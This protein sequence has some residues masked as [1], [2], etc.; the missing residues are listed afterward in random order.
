[1]QYL[2]CSQIC[3]ALPLG[4]RQNPQPCTCC[5]LSLERRWGHSSMQRSVTALSCQSHWLQWAADDP[6]A[7]GRYDQYEERGPEL[8]QT[9]PT[10]RPALPHRIPAATASLLVGCLTAFSTHHILH[11]YHTTE[12]TRHQL[13]STSWHVWR[14]L[15]HWVPVVIRWVKGGNVTSAGWQVTLCDAI[16][17]ASSSS[18]EAH[19]QLLNWLFY[20]LY[21]TILLLDVSL[22]KISNAIAW[23]WFCVST[24]APII[25]QSKKINSL[26]SNLLHLHNFSTYT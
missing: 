22:N 23:L 20:L 15:L 8:H 16:W 6:E 5:E 11:R 2:P 10:A 4:P 7:G 12:Q 26:L 14:H 25:W 21:F 9:V 13:Q 19:C 24:V 3:A 1:M 17:L 18:S